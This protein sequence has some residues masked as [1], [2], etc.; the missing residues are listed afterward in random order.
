MLGKDNVKLW[1]E[2]EYLR[3]GKRK[4]NILGMGRERGRYLVWDKCPKKIRLGL[5]ISE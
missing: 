3:D 4:G 1:V 2:I 5:E